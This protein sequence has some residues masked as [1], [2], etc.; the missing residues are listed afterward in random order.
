MRPQQIM[1]IGLHC[2]KIADSYSGTLKP[3]EQ[4]SSQPEVDK[5]MLWIGL[6]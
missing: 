1:T 6:Q 4:S 3:P 5:G 2:L